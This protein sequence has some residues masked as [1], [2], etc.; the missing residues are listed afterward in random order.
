MT[1]RHDNEGEPHKYEGV[2]TAFGLIRKSTDQRGS[3]WTE[4]PA[5]VLHFTP[6][7]ADL[8]E[9]EWIEEIEPLD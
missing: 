1:V 9:L 3:E 2:F 5:A 8:I 6:D 7:K 4:H